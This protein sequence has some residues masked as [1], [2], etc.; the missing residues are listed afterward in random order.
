MNVLPYL[1]A[2]PLIGHGLA[3]L[4]GVFAPWTKSLMGYAD[5]SW[6]FSNR[7]TLSSPPGRAYSLVWLAASTCL[8]IGGA[9]AIARQ[10]FWIPAAVLGCA[11]SLAAILPWWKAVPPGAKVGAAFDLL[12]IAILLSPIAAKLH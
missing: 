11:L 8:V 12:V 4:S 9:G 7:I 6:L 3:H 10:K 1:I 2:I 5:A